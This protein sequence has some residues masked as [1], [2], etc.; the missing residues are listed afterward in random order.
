M[1]KFDRME[2]PNLDDASD[3]VSDR[4]FIKHLNDDALRSRSEDLP[5]QVTPISSTSHALPQDAAPRP[6]QTVPV[7]D[8][9]TTSKAQETPSPAM[10]PAVVLAESHDKQTTPVADKPAPAQAAVTKRPTKAPG[11]AVS[12]F[13]TAML[14]VAFVTIAIATLHAFMDTNTQSESEN[15][16]LAQNPELTAESW[17]SGSFASDFETFLSDHLLN[18]EG[19]IGL[20]QGFDDLIAREGDISVS[21]GAGLNDNTTG[22][23]ALKGATIQEADAQRYVTLDD[24]VVPTYQHNEPTV[25][26]FEQSVQQLFSALPQNVD[27]Y[28]MVVPSRV[29]FETDDVRAQSDSSQQDIQDIYDAMPDTVTTVDVY[30]ALA[31]HSSEDI[32]FRTDHHWTEL[33]AYYGAQQLFSAAGVSY[34]PIERYTRMTGTSYLGY[35]YATF[36]SSTLKQHP[37]E[38]VYYVRDD[39]I[40]DETVTVSTGNGK[41]ETRTGKVVDPTRSGYDAFVET[42]FSQAIIEGS[43][44]NGRVLMVVSDSY[45]QAMAPWLADNYSKVILIDPRYYE[46]GKSGM[47]ALVEEYDVTDFLVLQST[48]NLP[49]ATFSTLLAELGE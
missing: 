41:Y 15:R 45:M 34:D 38:L 35:L 1:S 29:E 12:R 16:T 2:P 40:A 39:A 28:L 14:V 6:L 19:L 24:R 47:L 11:K 37:D 36:P 22:S 27:K 31:E 30:S 32:F 49:Y 4:L 48:L 7:P 25:V 18:R 3:Q 44:N 13:A 26:Y 46:D 43:A 9:S 17:F 21:T 42:S 5:I 10:E 20:A 33:G 8:I 23:D